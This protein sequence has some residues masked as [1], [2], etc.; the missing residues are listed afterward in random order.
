M[1]PRTFLTHPYSAYLNRDVPR[2]DEELTHVGP[3]TPGGEY[4]RRFWQ[5]VA[6][7]A[8]M[9]QRPR[10]IRILGEDL[11]LF[12]DG[13]GHVGLLQL[14]CSH[15][16]AS[17]EFGLV[18]ERGLRC[19]YHGWLYDVDGAILETP[20]EPRSSSLK[21]RLCHGAYPIHQ[22]N[23]LIFV[24]MGPPAHRPPFPIYDTFELPGYRRVLTSWVW[25]CNWI[26]I[27]ENAMDPA[28]TYFLH[29]IVSG[30]QFNDE[31]GMMPEHE[32]HETPLGLVYVATRRVRDLIWTRIC[33]VILP[34]IHQFPS[35]WNDLDEE[36]I[37]IRP[38]LLDWAVP[39]DDTHTMII[40]FYLQDER[41]DVDVKALLEDV[42]GQSPH[43][44]YPERQ[45]RPGDY[46]AQVLGR[47]V[48]VHALEHLASTDR[49]VTMFRTLVRKGIRAVG[50]EALDR[51]SVA[52]EGQV[53]PTYA[54]DT[55]L[56]IPANGGS[57]EA[58]RELLR[59]TGR[60]V[61][62]GHYLPPAAA[63]RR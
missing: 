15:R 44:P 16:G 53:V 46:E 2:E 50:A 52:G 1:A 37:F 32:W 9:G 61:L 20:G 8:D 25:P 3:G 43:R 21:A 59:E 42:P 10:R 11:V 19:C 47:P 60:K 62:A 7:S 51:I 33:E 13:G 58:D 35:N 6:F 31:F 41:S 28:H 55:I 54:Q 12:R 24:Y 56:R 22:Y 4:L 48:T 63:P 39:L 40:G 45:R 29:T 5:P 26:Q 18:S 34:N 38:M 14:Y 36:R 23:G 17:L 30:A 57:E 27:R 49:G